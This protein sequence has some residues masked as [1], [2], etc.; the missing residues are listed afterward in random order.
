MP[1]GTR[2]RAARLLPATRLPCLQEPAQC[3]PHATQEGLLDNTSISTTT[4]GWPPCR[5][6]VA[7]LSSLHPLA[8]VAPPPTR[9]TLEAGAARRV[10][11]T[12]PHQAAIQSSR[13]AMNR[14]LPKLAPRL[15]PTL[16]QPAVRCSRG[17]M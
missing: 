4:N 16:G 8:G 2:Y 14:R 12:V 10:W 13:P 3:T 17:S 11:K 15:N 6:P 5:A 1:V 9:G 7:L